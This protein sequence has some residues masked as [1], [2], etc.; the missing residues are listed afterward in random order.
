[1]TLTRS[2]TLVGLGSVIA[3]VLAWLFGLPELATLAAA[4]LAL[5]V[6]ALVWVRL[7]S[8]PLAIARVARPPRLA[9]GEHCE[10]RLVTRNPQRRTSPV[11]TLEDRVGRHGI[12][13]LVLAPL[14][15]G[16]RCVATYSLPTGRRG[17]HHVGPLRSIVEDPFGL[18]RRTRTD[19]RELAVI[20]LP[21]TWTLDAL[22][23]APGDE[24]EHGTH[25]LTSASSVDEEFAALRDYVPGDDV[26]RIHWRSTARRGTPV[27]R[28]FDVPWQRRTTVL[29]DLRAGPDELAFE[30]AVSAAASVVQ[31]VAR[32]DELV[33]LVTTDGAD[34]GFVPAAEQRDEL[35]DRLAVV[36]VDPPDRTR[37]EPLLGTLGQLDRARTGRL[38]TCSAGLRTQDVATLG[39]ATRSVGLHV[40]I[41][42][43]AT[44]PALDEP[45]TIVVRAE[46]GVELDRAWTDAV[47]TAGRRE[48]VP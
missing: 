7:R 11:T 1:M 10:I 20:V 24:P 23:P 15:P 35:M 21:R 3:A 42:T 4:A 18:A 9:V 45:A 38:V 12:A 2:G 29:L 17:L 40:V 28:Q 47:A 8:R 44:A 5:V 22:P 30:R 6:V 39:T 27:V 46:A 13:K 34:S 31:L 14:A 16:E 36:T 48:R 25:S 19:E 26:R 33:R 37:P 32:R 41:T 43:S